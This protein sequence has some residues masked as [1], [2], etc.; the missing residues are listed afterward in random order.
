VGIVQEWGSS[1]A[2]SEEIATEF[3][4]VTEL[5]GGKSKTTNEG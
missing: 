4:S 1:R 2:L 3:R 5:L